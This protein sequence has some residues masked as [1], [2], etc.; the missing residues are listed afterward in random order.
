MFTNDLST[1]LI[2]PLCGKQFVLLFCFVRKRNWKWYY[3]HTLHPHFC[4]ADKKNSLRQTIQEKNHIIQR[5][6]VHGKQQSK[7]NKKIKVKETDKLCGKF[8]LYK[9]TQSVP[10]VSNGIDKFQSN[11]KMRRL[12]EPQAREEEEERRKNDG[13]KLT[14]KQWYHFGFILRKCILFSIVFFSNFFFVVQHLRQ[15]HQKRKKK[16]VISGGWQH[17]TDAVFDVF[18]CKT[19]IFFSDYVFVSFL[20]KL[21]FLAL[22]VLLHSYDCLFVCWFVCMS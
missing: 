5:Q 17:S 10:I 8:L 1:A 11:G 14:D 19:F 4:T 13:R 3:T 12:K 21:I 22:T 9:Q 15:T 20:L 2:F 6:N 18:R 7:K 16:W